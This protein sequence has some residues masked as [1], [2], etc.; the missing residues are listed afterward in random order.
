MSAAK[1]RIRQID[2]ASNAAESCAARLDTLLC[3]ID[4]A[5]VHFN[6]SARIIQ[7]IA[8]KMKSIGTSKFVS[9]LTMHAPLVQ[10]RKRSL[11]CIKS[12]MPYS[13][14]WRKCVEARRFAGLFDKIVSVSERHARFVKEELR[15]SNDRVVTIH[16]GIVTSCFERC[17]DRRQVA[18]RFVVGACGNLARVKRFDILIAA[19]KVLSRQRLVC[20]RIAGDGPEAAALK[21][22]ASNIGFDE[23][24]FVGHV[25][26][27]SAFLK[28]LHAFALTSDSEAFPYAILEAM[29][30]GLPCVATDVGDIRHMIRDS[31]DGFVVSPGSADDVA[32]R[33]GQLA[34]NEDL[35]LEMGRNA[36]QRVEAK[37]SEEQSMDRT[38]QV[39]EDLLAGKTTELS[40]EEP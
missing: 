29:G 30:S 4:P 15:L 20:L 40:A 8:T 10:E 35:R 14:Y 21:D 2:M 6:S 33:L 7:R 24:D 26:D 19:L 23:I 5:V 17:N 16:N 27:I 25:T 22:L 13:D 12:Y 39:F 18:G 1:V 11:T 32:K 36:R 38:I 34:E 9:C 31:V 3:Q 28:S 37:F